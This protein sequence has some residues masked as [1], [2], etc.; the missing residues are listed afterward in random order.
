MN[1]LSR[2]LISP[3]LRVRF[4]LISAFSIALYSL[5]P[6]SNIDVHLVTRP[7]QSLSPDIFV[8]E[9]DGLYELQDFLNEPNLQFPGK[10]LLYR[11]SILSPSTSLSQLLFYQKSQRLLENGTGS[12]PNPLLQLRLLPDSDGQLRRYKSNFSFSPDLKFQLQQHLINYRGPQS[13]FPRK[14]LQEIKS[15]PRSTNKN[16]IYIVENQLNTDVYVTPLGQISEAELIANIIDNQK[17][18]RDIHYLKGLSQVPLVLLL[19]TLSLFVSLKLPAVF[20]LVAVLSLFIGYIVVTFFVF[21]I[22]YLQLPILPPLLQIL[23]TYLVFSNYKQSKEEYEKWQYKQSIAAEKELNSMKNNFLSLFS[24]DLKTPLAKIIGITER[25][26]N[27]QSLGHGSID[28]EKIKNLSKQLQ[29]SIQRILKI[30]MLESESLTLQKTQED[31]NQI[32]ESAI[33]KAKLLIEETSTTIHFKKAI[34]FLTEMDRLLIEEVIYNFIENAL[35]YG[36]ANGN[37]WITI[38]E[39]AESVGVTVDDDGPGLA[40]NLSMQSPEK[41]WEKF[42]QAEKKED[43]YGL[44]LYLSKFVID[45]HKGTVFVKK[46]KFGG[47]QFGFCLPL[48]PLDEKTTEIRT[49]EVL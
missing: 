38:T 21:N 12:Q 46:S 29:I 20:S 11:N 17:E 42:Y 3:D 32:V 28:L 30:S 2:E 15:L 43:G 47:C 33:K 36:K 8:L 10:I 40:F 16:F 45:L 44:G 4:F 39:T 14:T 26:R 48:N 49:G 7:S 31:L 1:W 13:T 19:L 6:V 34:L 41:I 37:I 27:Q 9:V 5:I 18:R 35:K 24:H 23:S 25:L 22:F